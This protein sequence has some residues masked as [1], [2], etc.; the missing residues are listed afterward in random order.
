MIPGNSPQPLPQ[1]TKSS[2]TAQRLSEEPSP[3]PEFQERNQV[4]AALHPA[5]QRKGQGFAVKWQRMLIPC[6]LLLI[7]FIRRGGQVAPLQ[8]PPPWVNV[9]EL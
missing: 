1:A 4:Q 8:P 7:L 3:V 2:L 6:I 5:S 9:P